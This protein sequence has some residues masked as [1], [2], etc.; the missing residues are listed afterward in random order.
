MFRLPLLAP[1]AAA[2]GLALAA[3]LS[4]TAPVGASSG[5]D[6][7][8]VLGFKTLHDLASQD[9]G[10]CLANQFSASNGDAQQP[11]SRGLLV[12]RKADN[13]TAF[14]DGYHT[15]VNGPSGVQERLNSDRFPWEAPA[16]NTNVALLAP[17]STAQ[18][19][20]GSSLDAMSQQFF[21]A[22]NQDR[23]SNGLAPVALNGQL[24][25]LAT[26]RAQG[27]VPKGGALSHYDANGNLILR[28]IMTDNHIP[29]ITAG[30][31]LA[32]NN[33][34]LGDT[35]NVANTG[36]MNSPTHRAN[37]LNPNY[38]Q[39][40]IGLA[41]PDTAGRYYFVQLFLQA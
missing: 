14:T 6:C 7:Q 1:R 23:S 8:F 12:W 4:M 38:T 3:A 28:E 5:A 29:F 20:A 39:V 16:S 27:L 9:V 41:G 31:N 40:G 32:E 15:W 18:S 26:T 24:S 21:N 34:P 19:P 10:D 37:I 35:V 25:S 17:P 13:F 33:F 36:L 2:I 11:T 30:E 22:M